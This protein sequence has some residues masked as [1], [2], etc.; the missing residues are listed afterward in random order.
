M[1]FSQKNVKIH[2]LFNIH[3]YYDRSLLSMPPPQSPSC[4]PVGCLVGGLRSGDPF[5][6]LF[7][8]L[9]GICFSGVINEVVATMTH[10][11]KFSPYPDDVW[12]DID[13]GDV[14]FGVARFVGSL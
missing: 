13:E 3:G 11:N 14:R 12:S 4:L 10:W 7:L 9:V 5:L 6:L 8:V 2:T 1:A